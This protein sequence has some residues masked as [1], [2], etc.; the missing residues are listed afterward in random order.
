M[1]TFASASLD[2]EINQAGIKVESN[3]SEGALRYAPIHWMKW[4][5]ILILIKLSLVIIGLA[6]CAFFNQQF[7]PTQFS[8]LAPWYR[9]DVIEFYTV[10]IN[11]YEPGTP[12]AHLIVKFPIVPLMIRGIGFL[13][14]HNLF[15]AGFIMATLVS[16]PIPILMEK[17]ARLDYGEDISE[18][19]A[20]F[21]LIF[22]MSFCLHLPLTE[23]IFM[24]LA[25]NAFLAARKNDWKQAAITAALAGATRVN[26]IL[27]IPA[28][29]AEAAYQYSVERKWCSGWMWL[30]LAPLGTIIYCG[31]CFWLFGDVFAYMKFQP[32]YAGQHVTWPWI[33][34]TNL[35]HHALTTSSIDRFV[36]IYP[37]CVAL[38][39]LMVIT[40]W[41]CFK[42]RPSYSIWTALNLLLCISTTSILSLP[43][44]AIVIFPIYLILAEFTKLRIVYAATS[45][46]LIG[47]F[48]Y[49]SVLFAA[50]WS[51]F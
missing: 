50:G 51:A 22:P 5:L 1:K 21:L 3:N 29:V 9:W 48:V 36:Y 28:L 8:W 16:L 33:G 42:Y 40:V 43:R 15:L 14:I 23:G 39:F 20:W 35:I 41:T 24:V 44:Y 11:G 47:F 26:G 45:C 38:V 19:S 27:L 25:L 13:G 12:L 30:A 7:A 46:V 18:R 32:E 31:L 4:V 10:T 6:S 49:F 2:V 17:L 37:E 34:I